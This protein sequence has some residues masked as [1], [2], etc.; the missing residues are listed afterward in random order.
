MDNRL[1]ELFE[2]RAIIRKKRRFLIKDITEM[3]DKKDQYKF[4]HLLRNQDK[5]L[6]K[7]IE[8]NCEYKY[9]EM[10]RKCDDKIQEIDNE[11]NPN[12]NDVETML[13]VECLPFDE[14]LET[15]FKSKHIPYSSNL[16][17][18]YLHLK[19]GDKFYNVGLIYDKTTS[20][21]YV[22]LYKIIFE[23]SWL[24]E[25]KGLADHLLGRVEDMKEND[26]HV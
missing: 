13:Y 23:Y 18:K 6:Y 9:V 1:K 2:K 25:Y 19:I 7:F 4:K 15:Y 20:T 12:L 3:L 17:D 21:D 16:D 22:N 26:Y 10:L 14:E 11:I 8:E 5:K 24:K